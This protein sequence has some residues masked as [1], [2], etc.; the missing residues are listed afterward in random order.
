MKLYVCWGTHRE[1]FHQHPCRR[2]HRALLSAGHQPQLIKVRGLGVGPKWLQ[3][4][5][6]GR[7]EVE[8][9]SGQKVVPLLVTDDR[10]VIVESRAIVDW[11]KDNPGSEP[12]RWR[13]P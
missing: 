6:Q 11:A 5:T 7:R 9:I 8:K 2:A 13:S 12:S 3:W 1:P 10:E 4:S